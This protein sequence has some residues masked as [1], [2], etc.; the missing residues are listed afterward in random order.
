MNA[1]S[2]SAQKYH[3]EVLAQYVVEGLKGTWTANGGMCRCPTHADNGPSLSVRAGRSSI[4]V[5]CFAG[6]DSATV[7]A[8]LRKRG[9]LTV[10]GSFRPIASASNQRDFADLARTIWGEARTLGNSTAA[11]YLKN[12]Q[13]RHQSGELRFHPSLVHVSGKVRDVRPGL[14]AR[15]SNER[16]MLAI[17]RIFLTRDGHKADVEFNKRTLGRP[18]DGAVRLH[19]VDHRQI[20]GLAEGTETAMSA[21]DIFDL[22]VWATLGTENFAH[23]QI[24]SSV[25]KI[26][27]FLDNGAGGDRAE[28]LFSERPDLH[29]VIESRR[30]PA[31]FS[32]W[33]DVAQ[34]A[35][36]SH[37][38][39]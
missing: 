27:L 2:P 8:E 28:T 36:K 20:L 19:P 30:P 31:R 14:V 38:H 26:I 1:P 29:C 18:F 33:N 7:M 25:T 39:A 9:L 24:P 37:A 17:Q 21:H 13:I 23:V 11:R 32:D 34:D 12:R 10:D 6:C 22:P 3:P 35:A 4:L 16:G 5:K 15:V